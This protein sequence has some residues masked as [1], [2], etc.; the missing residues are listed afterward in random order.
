M[1][2]SFGTDSQI[3]KGQL[4]RGVRISDVLIQVIIVIF[5]T[6]C[7]EQGGVVSGFTVI[8]GVVSGDSVLR[9][10]V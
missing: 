4:L 6:S 5:T 8:A 9:G 2:L 7:D 10:A 1:F 3:R